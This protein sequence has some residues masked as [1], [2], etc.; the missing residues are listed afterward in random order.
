[1]IFGLMIIQ[2]LLQTTTGAYNS[3]GAA[4]GPLLFIAL[5]IDAFVVACWYFAGAALGNNSVKG[6]ALGEFYQFIG[7]VV[8]V[9]ILI[10]TLAVLG[11]VYYSAISAT[12]LMSPTAISTLCGNIEKSTALDLLG[13]TNSL[14]SG[15]ASGSGNFI[16]ICTLTGS[17]SGSSQGAGSSLTSKL[18]Y[19]LAATAVIVAN[20]TNQTANNLNSTFTMDAWIGFL[21]QLKTTI[22][23]CIQVPNTGTCIVPN[24]TKDPIFNLEY[25]LG[26]YQGYDILLNNLTVFGNLLNLSVESFIIQLLFISIFLYTWPWLLFGGL[27]LRSTPFTRNIGGLLIAIAIGGLLIY[28][29]IF[30]IEYLSLANG[31]N[32]Q[33]GAIGTSGGNYGASTNPGFGGLSPSGSQNNCNSNSIGY[34]TSYGFCVVTSLPSTS[35]LN[36]NAGDI[37]GNYVTNF[38]VEP[39]IKAAAW[40]YQCWPNVYGHTVGTAGLIADPGV[41]LFGST[42]GL[43]GAEGIDIAELV[44][45]GFSYIS[46]IISGLQEAITQTPTI[47]LF[48][49]CQPQAALNTFFAILNSYGIIGLISFFIPLINIVITITAITGLSGL[50]GGDTS[51]AGL[52]KI[53]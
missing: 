50:F 17:G 6:A 19:P 18:E 42:S 14:L 21:Q 11:G 47:S 24:P 15:P 37:A 52:S 29:T 31:F 39:N 35:S 16:G 30:A 12:T 43:L 33:T 46:S 40:G 1:M 53:L 28:P 48:V 8:L 2:I 38:F 51:L 26:V 7:T 5:M 45:P 13:S 41:A 36:N 27:I 4:L 20:L 3:A 34:N 44:V 23:I 32:P 10:G 22:G 25:I 49:N 9:G